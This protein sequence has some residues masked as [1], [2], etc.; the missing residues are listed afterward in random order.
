MENFVGKNIF[1]G[2]ISG[3]IFFQDVTKQNHFFQSKSEQEH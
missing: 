3:Y 1:I 2:K